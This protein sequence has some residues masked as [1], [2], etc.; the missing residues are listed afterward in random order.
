MRIENTNEYFSALNV[1]KEKVA[2]NPNSVNKKLLFLPDDIAKLEYM[3]DLGFP[4]SYPFTR[5]IHAD[6]YLGKL[7]T[8]RQFAGFGLPRQTNERFKFLLS[9]GQSGLSVAFDTPTIMGRDSDHPLA[10]GEVGR[11]GV[12]VDSIQDMEVIFSDIPLN[13]VT[14]SMTINAPASILLAMYIVTAERQGVKS[15]ELSGTIQNDILKEYHAQNTWIYP[16]KPSLELITDI[17]AFCSDYVPKWN[18]ISISGYHIREAGATALQ[19]L[20]FTLADGFA[21]VEAGISAGLD[22]DRFATRLSFFFSAH[23]NFFEEIAKFRAARRIWARH[24]REKYRARNPASW[25]MRFHTQT[26]GSTL[27]AQQPENNIVRTAF[28][29]LAAVLGQTQSLHTNSMDE[30]LALPTE[31][32]VTIALRTQQI[33]AEEIGVTELIDPLAGSYCIESLT[34]KMEEGA[35]EYFA[36]IERQGGMI[37]AI[38]NGFFRR[39][40][41]MSA[42]EYQKEIETKRRIIVGVNKYVDPAPPQLEILRVDPK[43]EKE[44][45]NNLKKFKETRDNGKVADVLRELEYEASSPFGQRKNLMLPILDCVRAGATLGEICDVFRRTFGEFGEQQMGNRIFI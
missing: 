8:M 13:K 10:E 3:H 34:Q 11:C 14:T 7:W 16:P 40:I 15:T 37:K 36:S 41:A 21:Y 17:M 22:V 25:M 43:V 32:A 27:T 24:M 23:S 26:A 30:A 19:E 38:E 9:Q 5:G 45:K 20:A 44:Q 33:I 39:E 42:Y 35:E 2:K 29:A 4:G 12:A 1:W 28:Q 18:T 31:K 6:M